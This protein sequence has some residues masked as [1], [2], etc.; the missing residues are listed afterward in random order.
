MFGVNSHVMEIRFPRVCGGW[1]D[2]AVRLEG[3]KEIVP[4]LTVCYIGFDAA[5]GRAPYG[6]RSGAYT[7]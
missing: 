4:R 2:V 6:T 1:K 3:K 5:S 7:L